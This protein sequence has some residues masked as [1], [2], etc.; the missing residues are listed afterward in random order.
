MDCVSIA[1]RVL[2]MSTDAELDNY[3]T[4]VEQQFMSILGTKSPY[5]AVCGQS[6]GYV[7]YWYRQ[8]S[9]SVHS[10]AV[11]DERREI[12]VCGSVR[13][14]FL[15]IVNKFSVGGV[16]CETKFNEFEAETFDLYTVQVPDCAFYETEAL[17]QAIPRAITT[18]FTPTSGAVSF[19]SATNIAQPTCNNPPQK[20]QCECGAQKCGA[21]IGNVGHSSWCPARTV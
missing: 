19:A 8:Y 17:T 5:C 6:T 9:P 13:N 1:E 16:V 3:R 18:Y 7:R 14:R 11:P 4:L 15:G 12:L 2:F 20:V 10:Y 21:T